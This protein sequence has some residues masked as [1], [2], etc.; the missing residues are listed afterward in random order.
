MEKEV[1]T[2]VWR[3]IADYEGKYEVS[4]A[5]RVRSLERT[6]PIGRHTRTV[7]QRIL[8]QKKVDG[9]YVQVTLFLGGTRKEMLV[10][11][12]VAAA[13]CERSEGCNVVNHLD[14][15]P[16]NNRA[17]NLEWTTQQGNIRHAI[18]Q[19]RRV[20]RPVMNSN[21]KFYA[22]MK[23]A[24]AD[25][26]NASEICRVCRGQARTHKGLEWWYAEEGGRPNATNFLKD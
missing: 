20:A 7:P 1:S 5:G 26:F 22:I 16:E 15:D 24:E 9:G 13:F 23:M 25:G 2:E 18:R 4:N 8:R 10:H 17:D 6:V 19:G 21:N 14:N 12:L 3:P 11:R